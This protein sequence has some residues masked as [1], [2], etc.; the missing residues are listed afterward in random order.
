MNDDNSIEGT[1]KLTSWTIKTAIDLNNDGLSETSFAPGCLNGS[2]LKF[3]DASNG[4]LFF[5]S[6]VSYNT[7]NEDGNLFFMIACSTGSERIPFPITYT[8][9]NN[10]VTINNNG[11]LIT[12]TLTEN[13]LSMEVINGFVAT[14][15]DTQETT[16]SEDVTYI[17]TKQ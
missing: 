1:W 13:A 5:S 2:N 14:D 17:F 3:T 10:T 6:S 4:S 15:V 7:T 11:E 9:N 12:L 8:K 16:V